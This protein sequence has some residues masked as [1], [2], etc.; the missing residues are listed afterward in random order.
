M[1]HFNFM[2][3]YYDFFMYNKKIA[4]TMLP[5]SLCFLNSSKIWKVIIQAI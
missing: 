1:G 3:T 5:L 2:Y 4:S